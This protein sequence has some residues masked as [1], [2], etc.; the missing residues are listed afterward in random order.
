M[1]VRYLNKF[2]LNKCGK[3]TGSIKKETLQFLSNKTI[4]VD[5]SIYLYK[6]SENGSN[7]LENMCHLCKLFTYY[8]INPIFVFDGKPSNEK[9][10]VL[11][12]RKKKK[13]NAELLYNKLYD[14]YLEYMKNMKNNDADI[15]DNLETALIDFKNKMKENN[16]HID[17]NTVLNCNNVD[18]FINSLNYI[19]NDA[20]SIKKSQIEQVKKIIIQNKFQFI[21]APNEADELCSILV[22]QNIAWACLSDDM[23]MF[24]YGCPRIIRSL[25]IKNRSFMFYTLDK[26]LYNMNISQENLR[27]ICILCGTDYELNQTSIEQTETENLSHFNKICNLYYTWFHNYSTQYLFIDWIYLNKYLN[28]NKERMNVIYNIFNIDNKPY[29]NIQSYSK[30]KLYTHTPTPHTPHTLNK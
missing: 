26:I 2:I 25:H 14:Y 12:K 3:E 24:V 6:F 15:R 29:F 20:L 13:K 27:Y 1:G 21:D 28:V 11:E 4:A 17:L 7:L 10:S 23:D 9:N 8:K 30:T 16:L 19:K 22:K 18:V 5:I